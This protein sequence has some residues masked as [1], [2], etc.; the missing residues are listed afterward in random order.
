MDEEVLIVGIDRLAKGTEE[1]AAVL[2]V[3]DQQGNVFPARPRGSIERRRLWAQQPER[4]VGKTATI[5]FQERSIHGVPRFPVVVAIRN[6][7]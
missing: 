1:G 5:R 2:S 6:Y 7:E 4:I 3:Q